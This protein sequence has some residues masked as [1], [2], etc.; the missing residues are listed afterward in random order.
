MRLQRIPPLDAAETFFLAMLAGEDGP[1]VRSATRAGAPFWRRFLELAREHHLGGFLFNRLSRNE[2]WQ[3]F[4]GEVRAA[5]RERHVQTVF[6]NTHFQRELLR[7]VE[8]LRREGITPLVL[9]GTALNLTVYDDLGERNYADVDLLIGRE[10]LDRACAAMGKLDYRIDETAQTESFYRQHHF[11]LIFRHR[12]RQWSCFEIHWDLSLPIMD[13]EFRAHA[14]R[15]RAATVAVDG[16]TVHLPAPEDLLLHLCQ[17]TSLNAFSILAQIRD[18]HAVA[19]WPQWDLDPA[20]FWR[21]AASYRIARPAAACLRLAPL[22][23][24][25]LRLERLR[26]ARAHPCRAPSLWSL[27]RLETIVRRRLLV[28][29]AG[30]RAVSLHRRDRLAD[31][32][33]F[34]RRLVFPSLADSGLD[35]HPAA[36]RTGSIIRRFSW[37]GLSV[38]LRALVYILLARC[39]WEVE[40]VA[41]KRTCEPRQQEPERV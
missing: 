13:T 35:G 30:G 40:P 34:L 15:T 21:R 3:Y 36:P 33:A 38:T 19:A 14:I 12:R 17:H 1:R 11:H 5:L 25:S 16:E 31:R 9:K 29:T 22:F 32:W 18:I 4:P 39:G 27:L 28:S 10:E 41:R 7:V 2:A 8:A 20:V 23:G 6:R 24:E 26:S 37:R